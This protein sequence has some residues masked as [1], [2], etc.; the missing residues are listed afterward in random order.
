M[1]V[2][3]TVN[4]LSS[5][6]RALCERYPNICR[7]RR[8]GLSRDGAPLELLSIGGGSRNALVIGGPHANE[9]AG[10]L[11]VLDLATMLCESP[12]LRA[13]LGFA[14]HF[15]ACADPD[16]ARLNE[17][18]FGGP[19][20]VGHH[21]RHHYRPAMADQPEWTFP[22]PAGGNRVGGGPGRFDRPLPE[23][24]AL[25]AVIDELRPVFMTSLHNADFSGAYFQVS[26]D[27]PGLAADLARVAAGHDVP[28]DLAPIDTVGYRV[29]GPG[30]F[31]LP[32]AERID[33]VETGQ[34]TRG[35]RPW[36][37]SSWHYADRHHTFT[38]IAE[39]PT[40]ASPGC[41]DPSDA[42][43][44]R[45]HLLKTAAVRLREEIG[46]LDALHTAVRGR[47]VARTPFHGAVS[48]TL[49]VSRLLIASLEKAASEPSA[50]EPVS[51]AEVGGIDDTARRMPLRSAAMF[52][53]LL[54]AELAAGN[55]AP[56]MA[57]ARAEVE[58]CLNRL[59]AEAERD[60]VP[61][62]DPIARIAAIQ[63][64]ATLTTAR[65]LAYAT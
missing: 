16:G 63:T 22:G 8:I 13:G 11:T 23:T 46:A 19:Y 27:L 21:H 50:D 35:P 40:W 58:G 59:C 57:G 9:P 64:R 20:T 47:F 6:L 32:P 18:W 33:F 43:R 29:A 7:I 42:G 25:M 12:G 14:W 54:D 30:V 3:P 48:D 10:F 62:A 26:R 36:G 53:R 38:L 39:V 55:R 44:S 49:A 41:D 45:G 17:G 56:V 65:H 52:L 51:R 61:H 28:L 5:S 4:E 60:S 2:V 34:V 15:V 31:L 1:R 37:A 24:R